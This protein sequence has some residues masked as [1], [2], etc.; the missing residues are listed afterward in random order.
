MWGCFSKSS[1]TTVNNF[2]LNNPP[3]PPLQKKKQNGQK[4]GTGTG[5]INLYKNLFLK[6]PLFFS[7]DGS[8]SKTACSAGT[9]NPNTG[10]TNSTACVACN[11]GE[12]S[13]T[14]SDICTAC[15]NGQ[16]SNVGKTGCQDC[17]A[18]DYKS[19]A[20]TTCQTCPA[21]KNLKH[22]NKYNI[23]KFKQ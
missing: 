1:F 6:N 4:R 7:C 21:G 9:A 12:Y 23:R 3:P 17:T 10:Q 13:S 2:T 20:H 11:T 15:A 22:H 5:Y 8:G 18:G 16:E 14:G 19:G